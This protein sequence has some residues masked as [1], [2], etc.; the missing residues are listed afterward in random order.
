[1]VTTPVALQVATP[2]EAVIEATL[3]SVDAHVTVA[4]MSLPL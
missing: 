3:G 4:V 2:P 1:M